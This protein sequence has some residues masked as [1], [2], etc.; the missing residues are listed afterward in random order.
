[1]KCIAKVVYFS[2]IVCVLF[3]SGCA[4]PRM[5]EP[6]GPVATITYTRDISKEHVFSEYTGKVVDKNSAGSGPVFSSN[7][8]SISGTTIYNY[9]SE[10][11]PYPPQIIGSVSSRERATTV[12]VQ[13]G[14]PLINSFRTEYQTCKRSCYKL[15]YTSMV[16]TPEVNAVYEVIIE[17]I[18]GVT[19][20]KIEGEERIEANDIA[21]ASGKCEY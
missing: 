7:H 1:M 4:M 14:Q 6:T 8:G 20:Y 19:V 16:F 17:P 13:A 12:K 18:E 15:F 9:A 11:C 10:T 2:M 21:M 5:V 3:V